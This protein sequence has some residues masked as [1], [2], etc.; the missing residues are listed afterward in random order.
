MYWQHPQKF[1]IRHYSLK[2]HTNL[3]SK[4]AIVIEHML[5]ATLFIVKKHDRESRI[6]ELTKSARIDFKHDQKTENLVFN[7]IEVI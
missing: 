5:K 6:I 7:F 2:A 1:L 3:L 4:R